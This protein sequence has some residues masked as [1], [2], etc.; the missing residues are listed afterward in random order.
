MESSF[1]IAEL[2]NELLEWERTYDT[3]RA[4]QALNYLTTLKFLELWKEKRGN[5]AMCH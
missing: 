2:R 1:D 4:H 5:E 3:V